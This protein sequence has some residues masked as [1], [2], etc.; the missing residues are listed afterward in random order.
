[1]RIYGLR[2][3][4]EQS[5][6]QVKDELG[7][8]DFQ[9]RSDLAIRRHQVLVNRAFCFCWDTGLTAEPPALAGPGKPG[10]EG[11]LLPGPSSPGHARSSPWHQAGLARCAPSAAG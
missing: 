2:H 8:A 9:V 3:W 7:W 6:K 11:A 10:R 1:V 4:V 5:Y